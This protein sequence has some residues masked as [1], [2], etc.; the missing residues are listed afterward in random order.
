[1]ENDNRYVVLVDDKSAQTDDSSGGVLAAVFA[2]EAMPG[3]AVLV[4]QLN[5][6]PGFF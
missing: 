5:V 4:C 1:M 3:G 6:E 2:S